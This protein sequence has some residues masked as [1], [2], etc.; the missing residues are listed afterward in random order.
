VRPLFRSRARRGFTLLAIALI[1]TASRCAGEETVAVS[2]IGENAIEYTKVITGIGPRPPGSAGIQKVRDWLSRKVSEQGFAL[3]SDR[4]QA[5]TPIGRIEM[6]NLS[7]V[8]PGQ[9]RIRKVL[10][11]AHYD[12]KRFVGFDFVGANDAASSVALLVALTPEIQKRKLP[13]DVEID[14]VDGEEAIAQ[15]TDADSLYGSRRLGSSLQGRKDIRAAFVVD[16]VG[17]ADLRLLNE[18]NSDTNLRAQ[19]KQVVEDLGHS[20]LLDVTPSGMIDD[21]IPLISAGIPTLHL[22]DYTYGDT[23][24]PGKYWHTAQDTVD[25]LSPA[26]LSF[27]GEVILRMLSRL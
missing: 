23:T 18:F 17:D 6:V 16:M 24:S 2:A 20:E 21:H 25:K 9:Q 11:V 15:W 27:V 14:F 12:S 22:M 4:F 7:Y 26:S 19:L 3:Q 5:P 10:L 13:F 1:C 8:I